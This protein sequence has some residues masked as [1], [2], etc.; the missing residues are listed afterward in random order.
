[1]TSGTGP[2]WQPDT[3]AATDSGSADPW[4]A[5]LSASGAAGWTANP[6][7]ELDR[8]GRYV[9]GPEFARGGMGSIRRG[10]DRRFCRVI[11]VKELRHVEP[12]SHA[13]QRFLREAAI[14]A[15]LQHPSIVPVYDLGYRRDGLPFLCM[16]LV[17]GQ[18]LDRF[19]HA[20][21]T[22]VERR[23]AL[24]HVIAVA[25]AVAFAHDR[26]YVHRDLK[27][28]N[29]LIGPFGETIV[30]D[31]GLAKAIRGADSSE[32]AS[33]ADEVRPPDLTQDG[34]VVGTLP[35]M[36]PE[37]ANGEPV[38]ARSDVYALGAML[39]H[40]LTG[41]PP[42]Q[43]STPI[44]VLAALL[45][46][47][48]PDIQAIEPQVPAELATIVRTAMARD[49]AQRYTSAQEMARELR[50]FQ[51][52]QWVTAHRY[53][54]TELLILWARRHRTPLL[55]AGAT[56]ALVS[57]AVVVSARRIAAEEERAAAAQREARSADERAARAARE[58]EVLAF[59]EQAG[60]VKRLAATPGRERDALVLGIQLLAPFGPG[61]GDAPR[62][63]FDGLA[64]A[65]PA[66]IPA[67]T[68]TAHAGPITQIEF[69]GDGSTL[70]TASEAEIRI[71]DPQTGDLRRALAGRTR[72]ALRLSLSTDGASLWTCPGPV[73]LWDTAT[74][75]MRVVSDGEIDPVACEVA[76]F[77]GDGRQIVALESRE[78]GPPRVAAWDAAS[79]ALRWRVDVPERA[80]ALTLHPA[81]AGV[82]VGRGD[83]TIELRDPATG[84]VTDT[85]TPTDAGDAKTGQPLRMVVSHDGRFLA[86]AEAGRTIRA[87][88]LARHE[89]LPPLGRTTSPLLIG[90]LSFSPDSALLA[91]LSARERT[92]I[93]DV[94]KGDPIGALASNDGARGHAA[95]KFRLLDGGR[96]VLTTHGD[97]TIRIH[98]FPDGTM[99]AQ[100][101][102]EGS[103]DAAALAPDGSRLATGGSDGAL[104]LWDLRDPRALGEWT[105]PRDHKLYHVEDGLALTTDPGFA[106]W[107]HGVDRD[108]PPLRLGGVDTLKMLR[109]DA[110]DGAL[111]TTEICYGVPSGGELSLWDRAT[112]TRLFSAELG[113][114]MPRTIAVPR[115]ASDAAIAV[116][117]DRRGGLEVIDARANR[118]LCALAGDAAPFVDLAVSPDGGAVAALDRQGTTTIW[119]TDTCRVRARFAAE[120]ASGATWGSPMDP[121]NLVFSG[122]GSA[123]SLVRDGTTEVFDLARGMRRTSP[124]AGRPQRSP[125][126]ERIAMTC[127]GDGRTWLWDAER[128]EEVAL[129]PGEIA[130][131]VSDDGTRL[132]TSSFD[133]W[134]AT[135]TAAG[136]PVMR[137]RDHARGVRLRGA[138]LEGSGD[139]LRVLGGDRLSRVSLTRAGVFAA[140]CRALQATEVFA[141][142]SDACAPYL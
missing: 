50:R 11:A 79:G 117:D 114:S 60:E 111:W 136:D 17:E 56:I 70:A 54:P 112:G 25:E 71:W 139:Q 100:A 29:V 57:I 24:P 110:I 120:H 1:M 135:D 30:I 73:E 31:W 115:A 6:A 78:G 40:A 68:R 20:R 98:E 96:A 55:A 46:G 140:A 28:H 32:P 113:G 36:P 94:E 41:R 141:E 34:A 64:D 130:R 2:T 118:R 124:C 13:E 45:D 132:L 106:M 137:V 105:R 129:L 8:D 133:G 42:Y 108:A 104:R 121:G 3:E 97:G 15:Q 74:G 62:L 91:V 131:G 69:S 103:I 27:P 44:A 90:H 75:A 23:E 95:Q 67:F 122:D 119:D 116:V 126:L 80:V 86:L 4:A 5:T 35:Y 10:Y 53:S 88:D 59:A 85:W 82:F 63:A 18:S 16:K 89:L 7:D 14:T 84:Q 22:A 123:V 66:L 52:G 19:V 81:G 109:A 128:D 21:A 87:W 65:V 43:A 47:P 77:V 61:F 142:V 138:W 51:A 9:L 101:R 76:G 26:G 49:P 102:G 72:R 107:I 93:F 58:R 48:P 134:V 92:R 12:G 99:V 33:A 39:Y 38:D 127:A 83:R 125:D 37:Q